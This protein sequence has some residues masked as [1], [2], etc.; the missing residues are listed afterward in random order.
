ML[1]QAIFRPSDRFRPG[2]ALSGKQVLQLAVIILGTGLSLERIVTTGAASLPVMLG[3]MTAALVGSWLFGKLLKVHGDLRTMI[4]VGT[5]I[6]GASAVAAV[7]GVLDAGELDVAYAI[8]TIFMFNVIAVVLYPSIGLALHMSQHSFGL[9]AGTAINDV[10]SVVAAS[11]TYGHAAGNYAVIVKLTRTTLIIPIALF[12]AGVRMVRTRRQQAEGAT[13]RVNWVKLVPWF[14]VFFLLAAV[15]N[16]LGAFSALT[17]KD[18]G[19]VALFLIVMALTGIGLSAQFG[20]MR[21]TGVRP[22][23]LG[24][25]LWATVG[26]TS[27]TLQGVIR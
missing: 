7:A 6:C 17:Q 24:A 18:L 1:I 20:A 9:W 2:I 16:T 8:S 11:Y 25:L 21:K 23:V 19:D 10:S 15:A 12:L 3:T 22:L 27:L 13:V 26:L 4:G 14:I 5:G